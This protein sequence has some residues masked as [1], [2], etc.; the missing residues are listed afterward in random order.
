MT[1]VSKI[2][3]FKNLKQVKIILKIITLYIE[4]PKLASDSNQKN[5]SS[6]NRYLQ[7]HRLE[8]ISYETKNE[9]R[10]AE[11]EEKLK[12]NKVEFKKL[13][14]QLAACKKDIEDLE[15]EIDF[16]YNFNKYSGQGSK[17][18]SLKRASSNNGGGYDKMMKMKKFLD[19]SI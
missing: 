6:T 10:R 14:S 9:E 1:I 2:K 7:M 19:V 15:I 3:I 11:L 5:S 8:N 13:Y 17:Y 16:F 18:N 12:E 4:L